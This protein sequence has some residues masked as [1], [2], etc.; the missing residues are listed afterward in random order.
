MELD[1]DASRRA[2]SRVAEKLK[3]T[4]EQVA[5]GIH[6]ILAENMANAAR[7]HLGER[8]KDP[9]RMPLYAFGGAGPVHA[10]RVAEILHLPALVSP[11]GPGERGDEGRQMQN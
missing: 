8:G 7:T 10:Y 3:L 9:R 4:I 1:V 2:L 6:Q 5:W 11:F